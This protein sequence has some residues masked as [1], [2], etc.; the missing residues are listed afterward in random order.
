MAQGTFDIIHPGH[1]HYLTE[2][3][4]LGEELYVVVARDSRVKQRKHVVI[5]EESRRQVIESLGVV[6]TAILGSEG[7]IF[8]SVEQINPQVITLGYDQRFDI[9][10][11]RSKLKTN[12]FDEIEV[13]RIS[14]YDGS[15]VKS[16]SEIKEKLTRANAIESTPNQEDS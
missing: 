15:G 3:A 6:D 16:S 1:I 14:A 13:V 8:E 7:D 2:S 11:L 10:D 4:K 5:D 9:D 12:G